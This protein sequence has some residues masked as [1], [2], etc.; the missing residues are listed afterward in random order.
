M[1]DTS[2][3]IIYQTFPR[4]F[5]NTNA[6]L[7]RNGN[8]DENGVGK[9]SDYS[10]RMLCRIKELGVTH[11]WYAGVIEHATQTDYTAFGI[12]LDHSAIVKGK[13]GS[14]YAIKDYYDI[15]PDLADR[16][17]ARMDEFRSLIDRTHEAGLKVIIDFVPNHVARQYYS[18]AKLPY[19][20]NLGERDRTDRAFD[21]NNNFYYIPGQPLAIYADSQREDYAY[22]EFP[23]KATGNNRFD[24]YPGKDDWYETVKLNYGIDYVQGGQTHFTPRPDAWGKMLDILKFW[25]STGVDGFRC[26]MA[27][28]VPVEFWEWAIQ[29]VKREYSLVFIAEIYNPAAYRDYINRGGFD[30][31]YDKVGLYDTL[32][33]VIRGEA[34]A[35]NITYCWQQAEGIQRRMLNFL[36]N[37]D[38]QRIASDFF[39]GDPQAGF[40]GMIVAA[41]M[42]VNPVMI[43]NGQELGERGM[44]DEGFSGRDGRTTLFDYWSMTSVR[45][46]INGDAPGED[47]L[48]EAQLALRRSYARL[49]N[50]AKDEPVFAQGRFYDLTYAN[51][52][53]PEF[54][55]HRLYVYLRKYE[56]E[57]ALVA[58]NFD[59]TARQAGVY[60]PPEAFAVL[61]M[62][63]NEAAEQL[64]LF[65]GE[66]TVCALASARLYHT[67][68][69][70][71]GGRI[72]KFSYR[73]NKNRRVDL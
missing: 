38:E 35:S 16:I 67:E 72:L 39:A 11:I 54:N 49:L 20:E 64:D 44:D 17:P 1:D 46:W 59:K 45:R 3:M 33:A 5:G 30:Y 25:A 36:E 10:S 56:N 71:Y 69:P 63:E 12:R 55:P 21:R 34:P 43:Y 6:S 66:K 48:T 37:H 50:L 57:V 23:A 8:K 41:T 47:R 9:L 2:K 60:I 7:V 68:V 27:E 19:I 29:E 42:N 51:L 31:L 73:F 70:A 24:F 22:T 61:G 13:A 40:P 18:D 65:T 32:R 52:S 28:M 62:Q 14:P 15:D 53:N 58:V 26:D 4:L